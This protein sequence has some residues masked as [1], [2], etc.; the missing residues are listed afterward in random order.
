MEPD[1]WLEL[2]NTY[3]ARIAQRKQLFVEHGKGVLDCLPGGEAACKELMEMC[4]Q[5]LCARYPQYFTLSL[6]GGD[7][8]LFNKILDKDFVLKDWDPLRILLENIPEDFAITLPN[9]ETGLYE[10]RAGVICSSIGWNLATKIGMSLKEIHAPIPDYKDKMSAS[11]DRYFTKM[12]TSAPIQRGSWGLE[13]GKPLY[14]PPD[15]PDNAV[16]TQQSPELD[17]SGLFLRVDW[18]TLRRLPLSGGIVFNFKAL[19]T[20]I[21]E[22]RDEPGVPAVVMEVLKNGK[23]TL[24]EYKGTWHVEHVALPALESWDKEQ[25]ESGLVDSTWEVGM[26]DKYPLFEGWEEKWRGQQGF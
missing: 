23:K 14:L 26:L 25:R 5:F 11:M 6:K 13:H 9:R 17:L 12:P 10:F 24:M 19:F 15:H 3:H 22:F 18:Q 8:I 20:P 21:E 2:E 1:W 7:Y 4:T 16:R